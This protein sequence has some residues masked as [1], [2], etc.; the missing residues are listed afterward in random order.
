MGQIRKI[1]LSKKQNKYGF[2]LIELLVSVAILGLVVLVSTNLFLTSLAGRRKTRS[3]AAIKQSGNYVLSVMSLI[4]RNS[5]QVNCPS[6]SRI[7]IVDQEGTSATFECGSA[8]CPNGIEYNG[9]CLISE[10]LDSG[11][12]TFI[13]D[14]SQIPPV[15]T[16]SFALSRGDSGDIFG[17]SHQEFKKIISLRT[18]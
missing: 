2:T 4:I 5:Q 7:D 1:F 17:Y 13:C 10:N 6:G 11:S 16:I 12:C 9:S 8:S 3:L 18:Y 15:V 14:N